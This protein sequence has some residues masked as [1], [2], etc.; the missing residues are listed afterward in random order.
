MANFRFLWVLNNAIFPQPK[1]TYE[2][3]RGGN[4]KTYIANEK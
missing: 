4:N 2:K 3:K 1:K